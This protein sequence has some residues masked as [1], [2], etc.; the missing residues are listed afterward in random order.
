MQTYGHTIFCD[1]IRHELN[2]KVTLVGC[3][4]GDME[5]PVPGPVLYPKLG[6][7]VNILIPIEIKFSKVRL[8]V[9]KLEGDVKNLIFDASIDLDGQTKDNDLPQD[10]EFLSI[11]VPCMWSPFEMSESGS[12]KVRAELDDGEIIKL[13]SL[14]IKMPTTIEENLSEP[15]LPS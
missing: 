6:A 1:D 11:I 5:F 10:G 4:S 2:G 7:W 13:G 14:K 15:D 12:L 9:E 3:Y 8:F